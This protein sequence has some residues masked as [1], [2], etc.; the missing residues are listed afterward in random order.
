VRTESFIITTKRGRRARTTRRS[1][2]GR[3]LAASKRYGTPAGNIDEVKGAFCGA[4]DSADMCNA[5]PYVRPS[6]PNG[7]TFDHEAEITAR[8][9][10]GDARELTGG[11]EAG[12]YYG[13]ALITISPP[14]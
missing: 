1:P 9:P 11:T 12:N 8:L 6:W 13:S 7:K 5:N 4:S 3:L 10:D 14:S 2:S